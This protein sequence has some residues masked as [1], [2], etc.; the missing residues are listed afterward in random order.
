MNKHFDFLSIHPLHGQGLGIH[1]DLQTSQIIHLISKMIG[2]LLHIL[3]NNYTSSCEDPLLNTSLPTLLLNQLQC[4][5]FRKFS[6]PSDIYKLS[7]FRG[8]SKHTYSHVISGQQNCFNLSTNQPQMDW[9]RSRIL[10]LDSGLISWKIL[11]SCTFKRTHG[12]MGGLN[13]DDG[14]R[15]FS[16]FL[17]YYL[18]NDYIKRFYCIH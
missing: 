5:L 13:R 10:E 12:S 14:F 8:Y 3:C 7:A 15:C 11:F 1:C 9:Y 2:P 17:Q 18:C 6:N 4:M 16:V